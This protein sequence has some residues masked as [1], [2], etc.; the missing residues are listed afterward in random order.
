MHRFQEKQQ[1]SSALETAEPEGRTSVHLLSIQYSWRY[2][3]YPGDSFA[4]FELIEKENGTIV[5]KRNL[6]AI[7]TGTP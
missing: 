1:Y 6:V 3:E 7:E 4:T 2:K 5:R